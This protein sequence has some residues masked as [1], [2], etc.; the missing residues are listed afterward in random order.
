MKNSL[1]LVFYFWS[2][3]L[4]NKIKC[5]F[6]NKI[7]LLYLFFVSR[8]NFFGKLYSAISD[9][10]LI[11][12]GLPGNLILIPIYTCRGAQ[13]TCMEMS[14]LVKVIYTVNS[15]LIYGITFDNQT[16]QVTRCFKIYSQTFCEILINHILPNLYGLGEILG[17]NHQ[18]ALKISKYRKKRGK[19]SSV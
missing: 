1:V 8:G 3:L 6:Y 4:K 15:C 9:W 19:T 18:T 7:I 17:G 5:Y 14:L 16:M 10:K 12:S 11:F 2:S 13:L